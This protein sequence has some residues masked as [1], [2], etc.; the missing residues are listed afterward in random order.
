VRSC[1]DDILLGRKD[2]HQ[3][4]L[5]SGGCLWE[6]RSPEVSPNSLTVERCSK[7]SS[8]PAS[9]LADGTSSPKTE[10]PG[11]RPP[12]PWDAPPQR[13]EFEQ[14]VPPPEDIS[15][16]PIQRHARPETSDLQ[17]ISQP[18]L[19]HCL[20]LVDSCPNP[21]LPAG[22]LAQRARPPPSSSPVSRPNARDCQAVA[23]RPLRGRSILG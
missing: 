21:S 3:R 7:R 18:V 16:T 4:G 5:N 10:E 12:T 1:S 15:K 17:P 14:W 19:Q 8:G 13:T 2:Q 11:E 23:P 20:V 9:T 22:A 6:P